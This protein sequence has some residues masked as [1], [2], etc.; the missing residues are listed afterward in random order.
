MGIAQ[1][2]FG[3]AG[4]S[5][6]YLCGDYVYYL[7]GGVAFLSLFREAFLEIEKSICSGAESK[8]VMIE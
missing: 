6:Y 7:L 3:R 8:F 2:S 1:S 4:P 5:G